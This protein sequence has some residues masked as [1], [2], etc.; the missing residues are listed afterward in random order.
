MLC[1]SY[2]GGDRGIC[3]EAGL[4]FKARLKPGPLCQ[5]C[6]FCPGLCLSIQC[7]SQL[8]AILPP[9]GRWAGIRRLFDV[10]IA[11]QRILNVLLDFPGG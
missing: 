11:S 6:L 7:S 2:K 1:L 5:S 4:G 3:S 8:G 10:M 9:R